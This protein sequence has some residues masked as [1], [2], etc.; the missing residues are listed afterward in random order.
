MFKNCLGHQGGESLSTFYISDGKAR[1]QGPAEDDHSCPIRRWL[2]LSHQLPGQDKCMCTFPRVKKMCLWIS[3][4]LPVYR[5][6]PDNYAVFA[7]FSLTLKALGGCSST[8]HSTLTKHLQ[9][10][11]FLVP[12]ILKGINLRHKEK[13]FVRR[14]TKHMTKFPFTLNKYII[15]AYLD[16]G[17]LWGL[18]LPL[19]QFSRPQ[20]GETETCTM[21][22]MKNT[23]S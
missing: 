19:L 13:F 17:F 8:I 7:Q 6:Y 3:P 16:L 4:F 23:F 12:H 1:S 18:F 15:F 21:S 2:L 10:C 11:D 20:M 5:S 14:S 22:S 9:S